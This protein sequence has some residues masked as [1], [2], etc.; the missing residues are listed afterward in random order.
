MEESIY[1]Q[2]NN[3]KSWYGKEWIRQYLEKLR[4]KKA[5]IQTKIYKKAN[6]I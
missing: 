6:I 4:Q 5:N 2:A 1:K 3:M